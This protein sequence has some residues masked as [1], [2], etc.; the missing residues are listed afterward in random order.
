M[1]AVAGVYKRQGGS[2]SYAEAVA[3]KNGKIIFV[4]N[5]ADSEKLKGDSTKMNDLKGKTLLPGFIDP[6]IHASIAASVLPVEIV[7]AMEWNT[8]LLYSSP[9]PRDS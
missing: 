3:V 6:H 7:S 1:S 2:V 5:K 4:G 9:S 8:C